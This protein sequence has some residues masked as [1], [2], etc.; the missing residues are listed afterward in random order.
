MQLRGRDKATEEALERELKRMWRLLE[1]GTPK[2]LY[3]TLQRLQAG[4]KPAA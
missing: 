2:H 4:A 3:S 1:Q